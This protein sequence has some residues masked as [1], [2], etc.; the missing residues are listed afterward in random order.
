MT[1]RQAALIDECFDMYGRPQG[2][3][4]SATCEIRW[5]YCRESASQVCK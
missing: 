4:L 1:K 5:E 2:G 3:G